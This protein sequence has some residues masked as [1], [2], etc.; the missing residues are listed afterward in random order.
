MIVFIIVYIGGY[1][2]TEAQ[3]GFFFLF[4][5]QVYVFFVPDCLSVSCIKEVIMELFTYIAAKMPLAYQL[6]K[7]R[8]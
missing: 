6:K 7:K 3:S 2:I 4:L 5:L 8:P 1:Q